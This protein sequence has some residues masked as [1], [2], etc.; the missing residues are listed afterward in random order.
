MRQGGE[1]K[2]SPDHSGNK[3]K[4]SVGHGQVS[5]GHRCRLGYGHGCEHENSL[6]HRHG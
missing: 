3:W 5:M 6:V 1:D 4:E 2:A